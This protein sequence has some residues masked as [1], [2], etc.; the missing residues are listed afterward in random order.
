MQNDRIITLKKMNNRQ[1]IEK[2]NKC[3]HLFLSVFIN[4]HT[5]R[6]NLKKIM[7]GIYY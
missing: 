7:S 2:L 5:H 4:A 3:M 6:R 1:G